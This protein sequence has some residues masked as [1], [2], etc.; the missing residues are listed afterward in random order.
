MKARIVSASFVGL[1]ALLICAAGV[2]A[3]SI[4]RQLPGIFYPKN[5]DKKTE[6]AIDSVLTDK[7]F[8]YLNGLTSYWEPKF[9]TTLVYDGDAASLNHFIAQMS[10]VHGIRVHLTFSHDLSKE[11]G[12]ALSA[13]SW[14]VLYSHV[15]PDV[16]TIRINLAAPK[17][18]NLEITLPEHR[19]EPS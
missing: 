5:F 17:L 11:T 3:L 9:E 14:W 16:I 19:P 13:G 15:T 6:K 4:D 2:Y 1:L 10:A 18:A 8:H 12:S 7:Q